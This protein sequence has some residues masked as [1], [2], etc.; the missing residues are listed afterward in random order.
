MAPRS[1][2][3]SLRYGLQAKI[4]LMIVGVSALFLCAAAG[5]DYV[6]GKVAMERDLAG[7]ADMTVNR[8]SRVLL[9]PVWNLD[10]NSVGEIIETEMAEKRLAGV[11][12]LE[13]D[14]TTL[15]AGRRR[16]ADW[17]PAPMRRGERL[18]GQWSERRLMTEGQNI[19]TVRVFVTRRF[20]VEDLRTALVGSLLRTVLLETLLVVTIFLLIRR[21]LLNP[22][23]GLTSTARD[24]SRLQDYSLRAPAA[25]DDELGT[26][27]KDF[28]GM[29]LQ[30]ASRDRKLEEH[31]A[32][33]EDKVAERTVELEGAKRAAEEAN[34]AKGEF[35]ANVSHEI[36][37]PMNAILGMA[38]ITL[39]TALTAKQ[40]EY[41]TIIRSSARSL[42]GLINDILDFSKID[43]DRLEIEH[44]PFSLTTVL[45]EVTDLFRSTV[46][47][48]GIE[49]IVDVA[50]DVP[51]ELVGD[52]LR[53]RQVLVN[54]TANAFKFTDSGEVAVSV[55]SEEAGPGKAVLSFA[56][57]DTGLGMA[58]E[59]VE[60]LFEAFTQA[61]GSTTRRFG[62][63]GLGL[64]ISRRLVHLM[65][66]EIR[67]SGR[68]GQGATFAF[69]LPFAVHRPSC[70]LA[71]VLPPEF[72][73][74]RALVV[75][76]N[77]LVSLVTR[78]MLTSFGLDCDVLATGEQAL[79]VLQERGADYGLVLLDWR[80]PG[81][82]GM[83]VVQSLAARGAS[84]PPVI[85]MT[86]FGREAEVQ[87]AEAL[88]VA[89][90]LMKPVKMSSL[91]DA[92]REALGI[93][94]AED[95]ASEAAGS[96]DAP[97]GLAGKRVLLAEDNPIN[98][99]VA[100]ELL[101]SA[102]LR[103]EVAGN[104]REVLE[105]LA[106]APFDAV[107]MDLQM[108][109]LD[110]YAA[111][112]AL[113]SAG[114]ELPV[115]AMTAHAMRD[116]REK[117]LAA[118]MDDFVTKPIERAVLFGTLARH[119][120]VGFP[121]EAPGTTDTPVALGAAAPSAQATPAAQDI[122]EPPILDVDGAVARLGGRR[123]LL[124]DVLRSFPDHF[125]DCVETLRAALDRGDADEARILAH[126]LKGASANISALRL[127]DA[128]HEL[129]RAAEAGDADAADALLPTLAARLDELLARIREV[130]S[131][132]AS[133]TAPGAAPKSA[134]AP[135]APAA[136][137]A[138]PAPDAPGSAWPALLARTAGAL[139]SGD[140]AAA[141]RALEELQAAL[142]AA[143]A[144]DTAPLCGELGRLVRS[145]D[146]GAARSL[147]DFLRQ[148]A[149][150]WPA[151]RPAP[152]PGDPPDGAADPAA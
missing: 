95:R 10:A 14:G 115:V 91:F 1:I 39:S 55:T 140:A 108:P 99:Q 138:P 103:A 50:R 121:E 100:V 104:G 78:R 120:R 92:V 6:Q 13:E 2:G 26:L 21:Q 87:R 45:E 149:E 71:R 145:G 59:D 101:R 134:P 47:Q 147:L 63:T 76:D 43:A 18:Q 112:R 143:H 123:P 17:V 111:T 85:V 98:Q 151:A 125:G 128:A 65:G 54:L 90:F 66:G 40:R 152:P 4:A 97:P 32:L 82:D 105:A 58:Q 136:P 106:R 94:S 52:P 24:V 11:E 141:A 5:F 44:T 137:A 146:L 64:A 73:G 62:G 72:H 22:L 15:F 102:G 133:E 144:A 77:Q 110:G 56:V 122:P 109:E 124:L 129:E 86:A 7:L 38:D 83:E 33:L 12:V 75:E 29:L 148:A 9:A 8:L 53:L 20:M 96:E 135:P 3:H 34:A 25:A 79:E 36:R 126:T 69:T 142:P 84:L 107:L 60:R 131:E 57:R 61:D 139:E 116:V 93:V 89:A 27:V 41:V 70:R 114:H 16:D 88:G 30:I 68:P 49:M 130:I 23:Q 74:L 19:G 150:A 113:R 48:K 51:S 127:A 132:T 80:L 118:G 46:A 117:A 28:N 37:T 42:L 67:A 31:R 81:M 119:L 35:L